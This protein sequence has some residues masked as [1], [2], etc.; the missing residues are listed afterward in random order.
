[1]PSPGDITKR[2]VEVNQKDGNACFPWLGR[3]NDRGIPMKTWMGRPIPAARWV[4]QQFNG[5]L[6][7]GFVVYRTCGNVACVNPVHLRAGFKV[8]AN[9]ESIAAKLLV[10]DVTEIRKAGADHGPN[11]ARVLADRYGVTPETIRSIWRGESW[12]RRGKRLKV[13]DQTIAAQL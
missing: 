6:P 1:M 8:E 4:W 7:D 13:S 9:R 2:L 3:F 11:T 12:K 5:P 10:S